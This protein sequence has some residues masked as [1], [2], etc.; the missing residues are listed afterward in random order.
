MLR[1]G[2]HFELPTGNWSVVEACSG[3]RYLISSVTIGCLYAYLTY[4]SKLRRAVFIAAS[5]VVPVIANG[6]R[7]YMIVMIGHTSNMALATGVDHLI[8]GWIFFGIVMFIMFWIGSYWRQ[9]TDAESA[10]LLA[11]R[12]RRRHL[13]GRDP[14]HDAGGAARV[15]LVAK[16]FASLSDAATRNPKPVLLLY[17][18]G[19]LGPGRR[20]LELG[21]ELHA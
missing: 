8:Y 12:R 19:Q 1:N 16:A 3:V 2:T 6:L 13:A 20:V 10:A 11:C 7:A 5:I 14:Q 21:A 4:R 15:R 18:P 9:D 17:R